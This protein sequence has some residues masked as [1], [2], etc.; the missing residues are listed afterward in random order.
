[1]AFDAFCRLLDEF[2]GVKEL[3]LQGLGEPL[4]HARFFDMVRYAAARGVEVSTNTNLTALSRRRAEDCVKSGLRRMQVSLERASTR[5]CAT[6]AG[7]RRRSCA[8]IRACRRSVWW[9]WRCAGTSSNCRRW[10]A[11]RTSMACI[12]GRADGAE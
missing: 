12:R 9:R 1:M 7:S 11:W 10:C 8:S 3:H 2:E 4:L 6:C 5:C